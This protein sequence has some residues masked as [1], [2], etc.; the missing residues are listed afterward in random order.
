MNVDSVEY[1]WAAFLVWAVRSAAH[2]VDMYTV[3][4][5]LGHR[6]T[7]TLLCEWDIMSLHPTTI[8]HVV[9]SS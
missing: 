4:H 2:V 5:T 3:G 1:L 7:N 6:H 9:S 8:L